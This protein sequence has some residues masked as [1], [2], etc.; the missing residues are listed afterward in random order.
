MLPV[1]C[2]VCGAFPSSLDSVLMCRHHSVW[3]VLRWKYIALCLF[4]IV[5]GNCDVHR[6]TVSWL[7]GARMFVVWILFFGGIMMIST[8][9]M[10]LRLPYFRKNCV[11]TYV[12]LNIRHLGCQPF[13]MC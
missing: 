13:Q 8:K 10:L 11:G 1:K 2:P 5:I 3:N 6:L 4:C 12:A 9:C 7:A